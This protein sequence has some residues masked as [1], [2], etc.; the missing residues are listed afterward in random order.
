MSS[1]QE[2]KKKRG[3]R[4]YTEMLAVTVLSIVSASLWTEYAKNFA[5]R[6]FKNYPTAILVIAIVITMLSAGFLHLLFSDLPKEEKGYF[7]GDT[8]ISRTANK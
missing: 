5:S 1:L 3:L 2:N 8:I 6:H 4:F 7:P